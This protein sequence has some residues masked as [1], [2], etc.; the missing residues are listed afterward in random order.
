[1]LVEH[2][3]SAHR[4]VTGLTRESL[5]CPLEPLLACCISRSTGP[6]GTMIQTSAAGHVNRAALGLWRSLACDQHVSVR[7]GRRQRGIQP[8]G[9]L[10]LTLSPSGIGLSLCEVRCI[11]RFWRTSSSNTTIAA[12]A[13]AHSSA[14]HQGR[15]SLARRESIGALWQLPK[16]AAPSTGLEALAPQSK[17]PAKLHLHAIALTHFGMQGSRASA[18]PTLRARSPRVRQRV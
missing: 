8:P 10:Q 17:T 16:A 7:I 11:S 3:P 13:A 14:L 15:S 5:G 4:T 9:F 18:S 6:W 2:P 12:A 1:M